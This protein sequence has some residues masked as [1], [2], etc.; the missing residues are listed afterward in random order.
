VQDNLFFCI[1]ISLAKLN[2]NNIIN[3]NMKFKCKI[4]GY[5]WE[6]R[7]AK[8]KQCPRCKRYDYEK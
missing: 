5:E 2:I 1:F 7:V 4:C 3:N 8:P 6:S